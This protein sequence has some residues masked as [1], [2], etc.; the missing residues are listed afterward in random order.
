MRILKDL[1]L[2]L[3]TIAVVFVTSC[4]REET[5]NVVFDS[6]GAGCYPKSQFFDKDSPHALDPNTF[7]YDGYCFVNWNTKS[8]G[9]G[10]VYADGQTVTLSD[11][12]Y[13]FAQWER[14]RFTVTFD[15]NGGEGEMQPVA[16]DKGVSQPLPAN[17]FVNDDY[18][19]FVGWNTAID[20]TGIPYSNHQIITVSDDMT[21]YAQWDFSL[22]GA[23]NRRFSVS[24]TKKVYFSQGN[25]QYKA[26]DNVWR[27]AESQLEYV[28]DGN[29]N[30]AASYDG[31]IDLFGWGTGDEPAQSTTEYGSY[32]A[33]TDWGVNP[34]SNAANAANAWRT[35]SGD[36]W[37][38]LLFARA[39]ASGLRFAKA[40]V[41][42]VNGIIILPDDWKT[43]FHKLAQ[44]N[45]ASLHFSGNEIALTDWEDTFVPRGAVFLPAAGYRHGTAVNNVGESVACWT[46]SS[47]GSYTTAV[48]IYATNNNVATKNVN[49]SNGQAVR[50]VFDAD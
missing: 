36:E 15:A 37:N 44:T 49:C 19:H 23:V 22:A 4:G 2:L 18:N 12:L 10:T 41:N 13:L 31:W 28:G 30:I 14:G 24:D 6:N 7:V 29:S 32:G 46:S 34:I 20:G 16:F 39:T 50:L 33:F 9:S 3:M 1:S 40:T 11:D 48:E 26:S 27:F 43:S 42:G 47:D 38:Y 25:L 21:L 8:D 5:V 35:L 17:A 45:V